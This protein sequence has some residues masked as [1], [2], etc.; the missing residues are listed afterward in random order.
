MPHRFYRDAAGACRAQV[1]LEKEL[2]GRFLEADVQG[3]QATCDN[4]L[5]AL[6]EVAAGRR[7]RW[8]QTGNAHT[9]IVG[10]RRARIRA[11]FGSAPDLILPFGEL[12][13]ALRE[14]RA[15]LDG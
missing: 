7:K 14:W 10:R 6:D 9:L 15:L 13:Q 4:L 1:D 3:S 8:Q 11:E 5:A 12:V 2:L